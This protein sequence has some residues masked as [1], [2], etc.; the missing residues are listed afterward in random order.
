LELKHFQ[1]KYKKVINLIH[2]KFQ[3]KKNL[4]LKKLLKILLNYLFTLFQLVKIHKGINKVVNNKK[5]IEI[6]STP[7]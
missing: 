7:K 1:K 6:P 4:K 2:K 5:K 3:L